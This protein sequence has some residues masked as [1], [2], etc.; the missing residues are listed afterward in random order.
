MP[1]P[2]VFRDPVHDH[3]T[4]LGEEEELVRLVDTVAFQRL[5]RIHQNGAA[6][7]AYL[8]LERSRFSHALGTYQTGKLLLESLGRVMAPRQ[9]EMGP[10]ALRPE[11]EMGFK[12][13]CLVHDLGHP[14]FSHA[15]ERFFQSQRPELSREMKHE[16]WTL[17]ILEED[18]QVSEVVASQSWYE[19]ARAFLAAPPP[20]PLEYLQKFLSGNLDVDRFDYL[21]RD[22]QAS[23]A[24]YGTAD[25]RWLLQSLDIEH[26]QAGWGGA[27][28]WEVVFEASRAAYAIEHLL[29]ARRS[30]YAQVYFHKTVRASE[31]LLLALLLRAY[32]L[33]RFVEGEGQTDVSLPAVFGRLAAGEDVNVTEYLGLDDTHV[34]RC[35]VDWSR[36][37]KD[38]IL[39][40]L[41][42]RFVRRALFKAIPIKPELSHMLRDEQRVEGLR[43]SIEGAGLPREALGQEEQL[44]DYYLVLDEPR[45]EIYASGAGSVYLRRQGAEGSDVYPFEADPR[46]GAKF[47]RVGADRSLSL[48]YV[49]V[50]AE[51]E[52]RTRQV[53]SAWG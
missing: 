12:A 50:P 33:G 14:C 10:F 24:G 49:I 21:A 48:A 18:P 31:A 42:E 7:L 29:L 16:S 39:R 34:L 3:I 40:D 30:M 44:S 37:E 20:H 52:Q 5:R 8:G 4:F 23:G 27:A 26:V 51:A 46:A 28:K 2:K 6:F 45:T 22:T 11:A 9:E 13:A 1:K 53:I 15:G 47:S 38:P 41:S 19:D 35:V 43:A 32:R 17:R 25:F 36:E